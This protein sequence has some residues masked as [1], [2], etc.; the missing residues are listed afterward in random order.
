MGCRTA[1]GLRQARSERTARRA[2][3]SAREEVSGGGE[4][5]GDEGYV[6]GST[7]TEICGAVGNSVTGLQ[8]PPFGQVKLASQVAVQR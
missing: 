6:G 1:D 4:S 8:V 5:D 7:Q 3:A 2:A